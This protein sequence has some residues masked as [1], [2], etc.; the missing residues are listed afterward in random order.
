MKTSPVLRTESGST[1]SLAPGRWHR[2]PSAEEEE[3]LER[4]VGPA[5]DVGCG[6]GRHVLALS[7]MGVA[8]VGIDVSP[9][10]VTVARGRGATVLHG[11]VFRSPELA[12]AW[13]TVLLLDGNIGIGGCPTALL[14]RVGQLLAT[15]GRALVEVGAPGTPTGRVRVRVE[16]GAIRGPWFE[17]ARVSASRLPR[18][19]ESAGFEVGSDVWES[20]CRW[21]AQLDRIDHRDHAGACCGCASQSADVWATALAEGA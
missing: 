7:K 9:L 8:A 19:A 17:W 3:V 10:A 5:L 21:F 2:E 11:C 18:I 15:G 13:K 20:G 1:I 12:K 6:P 16:R 14:R 4:V